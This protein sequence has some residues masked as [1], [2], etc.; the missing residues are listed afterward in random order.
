MALWCPLLAIPEGILRYFGTLT[1]KV[2]NST[3]EP[4]FPPPKGLFVPL[5]ILLA[6]DSM[7][8]QKMGQK[9]LSEAG[10]EV[11]AVSN[12]AAAVKK[13][14]SEKPQLVVLDV[15]MPGYTG[16]EVCERMK[17]APETAKTPVLLTVGKMEP[18]K[19][20]EATRVKADG[21]LVKPFE[22]SDLLAAV[23]KIEEKLSTAPVEEPPDYEKTVKINVA[24]MFKQDSSYQEWQVAAPEHKDEEPE[25]EAPAKQKL[26]V[27][28]ESAG[29]AV[30]GDMLDEAG[31]EA[32]AA[33]L[34]SEPTPTQ[35]ATA[36]S[37]EVTPTPSPIPLETAANTQKYEAPAGAHRDAELEPT[38]GWGKHHEEPVQH[39]Q[40]PALVTDPSEMASAFVTKFGV[41]NPE[42]MVVGVASEANIP[43]L[44]SETSTEAVPVEE[45]APTQDV[46]ASAAKLQA[47]EAEADSVEIVEEGEAEP[48]A[49]PAEDDF[50]K[51][52]AA[53]MSGYE[54]PSAPPAPEPELAPTV[55]SKAPV[56]EAPAPEPEPV[57]AAPAP[58]PEPEPAPVMAAAP[59]PEPEPVAV[60]AAAA[61]GGGWAAQEAPV[62]EHEAASSLDQEM[63]K[64]F[65][66]ALPEPE[67]H[68]PEPVVEAAPVPEPVAAAPA[69]APEP[70]ANAPDIELAKSLAAAVAPDA[71]PMT[72]KMA[73]TEAA[74]A[75]GGTIDPAKLAEAIHRALDQL[76]PELIAK[77]AKEL[78]G[79]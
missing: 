13:I 36:P 69:P 58:E 24:E 23:K 34:E 12:G 37:V 65:S 39:A 30:F 1:Y 38:S 43:G 74:A 27:P 75:M 72:V 7:T 52:V 67:P 70:A 3:L 66:A 44:Y 11:V 48:A 15:Y 8:A 62:A 59:V 42:P 76:K 4:S 25:H 51:R 45:E 46:S 40:D 16:L 31:P 64:A 54:T 29:S 18:F 55:M 77:I 61:A 33:A 78:E 14:A 2:I 6:D 28:A 19:A 47:T 41:D 79:K 49:A 71:G 63:L 68:V 20:E 17:A 56:I 5:K 73:A 60:A 50:E 35:Y 26:V 22:A 57:V 21:V 9:I 10:H 32:K 53:A